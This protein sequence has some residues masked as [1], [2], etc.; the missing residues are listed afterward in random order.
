M[1][2]FKV[3][4]VCKKAGTDRLMTVMHVEGPHVTCGWFSKNGE[5]WGD[6]FRSDFQEDGLVHA[7]REEWL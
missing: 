3:G 5:V 6:F 1:D 7:D 2:K 4:D